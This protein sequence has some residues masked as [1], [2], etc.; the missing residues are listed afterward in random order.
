MS[1]VSV[2]LLVLGAGQGTLFALWFRSADGTSRVWV[3]SRLG[4][5]SAVRAA[6]PVAGAGI[7]GAGARLPGAEGRVPET[8]AEAV[9]LGAECRHLVGKVLD[10]LRKY[11]V[12]EGWTNASDRRLGCHIGVAVHTA[13]CVVLAALMLTRENGLYVG[14]S[15][16]DQMV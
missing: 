14:D 10:L 2:S 4:R 8:D 16:L 6:V 1:A 5:G 13:G 15:Q 3:R 12:A 9:L 11:G 7:S